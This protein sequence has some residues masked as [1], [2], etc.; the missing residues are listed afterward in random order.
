MV[1]MLIVDPSG[2]I[3]EMIN[4]WSCCELALLLFEIINNNK[5]NTNEQWQQQQQQQQL[6]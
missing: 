2:S 6:Q 5:N 1:I 4:C 3:I